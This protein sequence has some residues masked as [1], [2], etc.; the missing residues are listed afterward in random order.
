V[1]EIKVRGCGCASVPPL[2][3]S[4]GLLRVLTNSAWA[5]QSTKHLLASLS[6]HLMAPK[7]LREDSAIFA[8]RA[9]RVPFGYLFGRAPAYGR[10][11][12][13][14]G[15]EAL[16]ALHNRLAENAIRDSL[17]ALRFLGPKPLRPTLKSRYVRLSALCHI[18]P[19]KMTPRHLT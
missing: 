6:A 17:T 10:A 8:K 9:V 13:L 15:H 18:V 14:V 19:L 12:D 5:Q 16:A 11:R 1:P 2:L 4:K 7:F 3:V